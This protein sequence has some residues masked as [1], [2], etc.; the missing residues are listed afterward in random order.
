MGRTREE[1]EEE[2][3]QKGDE[4][5]ASGRIRGGFSDL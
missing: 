1:E 2:E 3:S 5:R 4:R